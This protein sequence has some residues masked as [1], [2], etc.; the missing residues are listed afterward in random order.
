MPAVMGQYH[1]SSNWAIPEGPAIS[2]I[3][4]V[5]ASRVPV[6]VAGSVLVLMSE[7]GLSF[8]GKET[9]KKFKYLKTR[10]GFIFWRN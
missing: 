7:K 6:I 4:S 2:S 1:L 5:G 8:C 10:N 3:L 9:R